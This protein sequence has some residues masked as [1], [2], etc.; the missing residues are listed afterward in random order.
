MVRN[1]G[2]LSKEKRMSQLL[3]RRDIIV[4]ATGGLAVILTGCRSNIAMSP[5]TEKIFLEYDETGLDAEYN[6]DAWANNIDEIY[7]LDWLDFNGHTNS[8]NIN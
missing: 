1:C 5:G 7:S 8:S 3:S 4:A 2:R 6:Q